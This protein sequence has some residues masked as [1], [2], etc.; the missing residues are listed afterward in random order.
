MI[1]M[2]TYDLLAADTSWGRDEEG[3]GSFKVFTS[4]TPGLPNTRAGMDGDGYL[5]V[6][7]QH[8]GT[9]HHRSHDRQQKHTR[10]ER[11]LL[12]RLH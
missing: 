9:V 2:V 10:A 3:D 4:P 6:S 8:I 11:Q 1:D 12:L 7:G 5:D